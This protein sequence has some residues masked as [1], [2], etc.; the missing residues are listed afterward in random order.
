MTT[1]SERSLPIEKVPPVLT[2]HVN[3]LQVAGVDTAFHRYMSH[4]TLACDF[5]WGRFYADLFNNT[6]APRRD[7]EVIRLRLAAQS[8]CSFCRAHD[9][10]SAL[11]CNISQETIDSLFEFSR[12]PFE[13]GTLRKHDQILAALA[14]SISP[15]TPIFPMG[16]A[17]RESLTGMYTDEELAEVLMITG[18]LAGIGAMLVAA[19]FVPFECEL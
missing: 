7:I 4:S 12:E 9:V 18:V 10:V 3:N 19:G 14:D 15:F 11:A 2:Q 17:L 8:G 6:A 16:T 5:Y 1:F 13:I